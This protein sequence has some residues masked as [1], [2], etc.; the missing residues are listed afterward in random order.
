MS[1]K[2]KSTGE[3]EK[4]SGKGG[5][6]LYDYHFDLGNSTYGPIGFCA[7]VVAKSKRAAL[8]KLIDRLP[9]SVLVRPLWNDDWCYKGEY[10]EIYINPKVITTDDIDD[11][12]DYID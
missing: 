1:K 11:F 4:G 2:N 12:E 9:E 10:I 3:P 7:R 5:E 8:A 6:S